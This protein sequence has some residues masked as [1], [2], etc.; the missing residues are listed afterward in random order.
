V[1]KR[2]PSDIVFVELISFIYVD[3]IMAIETQ[4][5]ADALIDKAKPSS[6]NGTSIPH[7]SPTLGKVINVCPI[8]DKIIK[9][10]SVRRRKAMEM[11]ADL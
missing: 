2:N 6:K 3:I 4:K 8:S 7:Y 9:E 11:L 5:P 10:I 1:Y